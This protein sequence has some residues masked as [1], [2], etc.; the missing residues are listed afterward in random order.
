MGKWNYPSSTSKGTNIYIQRKHIS[1]THQQSLC[2]CAHIW[3]Q[4]GKDLKGKKKFSGGHD[5]FN[6][7]RRGI[8]LISMCSARL[9]FKCF[10]FPICFVSLLNFKGIRIFCCCLVVSVFYTCV[11]QKNSF[12]FKMNKTLQDMLATTVNIALEG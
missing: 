6:A 9:P 4:A 3:R 1:S 8:L 7:S 12:L 10:I 11:V 5:H 2:A